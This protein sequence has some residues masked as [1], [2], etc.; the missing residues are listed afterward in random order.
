MVPSNSPDSSM[1]SQEKEGFQHDQALQRL[2]ELQLKMIGGEKAND[3]TLKEKRLKRKRHAEK[4][5]Q[6]LLKNIQ[7]MEDDGIMIK[8]YDSLHDD[9]KNKT[10]IV[11]N[12]QE[13]LTASEI[14][15]RDLQGEFESERQD[16]Y[17]TIRKQERENKLNTQ[18][19]ER[20]Q[21]CIRRDCNYYNMDKV[22]LECKW[23]DEN[24][25][26]FIPDLVLHK[27]SLPASGTTKSTSTSGTSNKGRQPQSTNVAASSNESNHHLSDNDEVAGQE[28]DKYLQRLNKKNDNSSNYFKS[29]RVNQLLGGNSLGN[30][31]LDMPEQ[32]KP[33]HK[34]NGNSPLTPVHHSPKQSRPAKLEALSNSR[35]NSRHGKLQPL[36]GKRLGGN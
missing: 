7:K 30:A 16:L 27:L 10:K 20:I 23:D 8:V 5:R 12:L 28:E 14:E 17:E 25:K 36:G 3:E 34:L 26:W 13:R 4:K 33:P 6:A 21:G 29:K 2:Q 15:I 9:I 31:G 22:R 1:H 19:L 35:P 32:R 11:E 24:Q 18:I